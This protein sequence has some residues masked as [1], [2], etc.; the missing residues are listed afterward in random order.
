MLLDL[1]KKEVFKGWRGR[2]KE[3]L[4]LERT[5]KIIKLLPEDFVI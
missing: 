4:Y 3:L 2:R 5:L 1:F